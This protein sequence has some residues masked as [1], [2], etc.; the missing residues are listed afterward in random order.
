MATCESTMPD[1]RYPQRQA[2]PS[3]PICAVNVAAN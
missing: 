2:A 3:L 1:A